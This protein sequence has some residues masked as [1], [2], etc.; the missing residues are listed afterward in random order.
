MRV[1]A[2]E[3]SCD[4]TAIAI[5]ESAVGAENCPRLLGSVISTQIPIHRLYGGV[6]PEL[7]SRNHSAALRGVLTEAL[8]QANCAIEDID[9]FAGTAGPG[10][11]AALL[12]GN[13]AAKA[14]ALAAKKP[15]IAV[16]HMEG[17][18]LSP[19]ISYPHGVKPHVALVVSGGHSLLIHVKAHDDYELLGRSLD[20]A[21]GEAFDKAAKMLNLPYPGGPEIDRLAVGGDATRFAMPRPLLHDA[22]L[23]F[24]FS[25]LKTALLYT[26]PK[27]TPNGDP[28][29]LDEQSLRDLCA[30]VQQAILDVLIKKALSALE[31]TGLRSLALSGGVSCNRGLRTQMQQA[32]EKAG[33]E[34]ILAEPQYTTDNAAMIAYAAMLQAE[35]G[36][37]SELST[38]VDPNMKLTG[39]QVRA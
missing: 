30:S 6:I 2:I 21:A 38:A 29:E 15:Y 12:I 13:S 14:L 20:D 32:C 22:Q 16:N 11:V 35:Q 39:L 18:L 1:L 36:N 7:A 37:F 19:F 34:L 5:L 17:H 8:E 4:E 33:I 9:V 26:L 3:S 24:S 28:R 31:Q 10:L 23:N 27:V 25:G